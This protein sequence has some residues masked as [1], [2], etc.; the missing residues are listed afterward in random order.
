MSLLYSPSATATVAVNTNAITVAGMDLSAV[1]PGMVINLGARDRLTGDGYI[2]TAVTPN[3]SLGGTLTTV[4]AIP[5]AFN[6]AAFV[7]DTRD[8]NGTAPNYLIAMYTQTLATLLRLTSPLTNLFS[9]S[10]VLALD[11]ETPGA[12]SR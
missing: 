5:T 10:R 9:G 12:I 7:V 11:K 8:F 1:L 2:I 6:N 4:G 3:G